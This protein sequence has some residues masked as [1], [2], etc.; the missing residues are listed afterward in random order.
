MR[1]TPLK[2][3]KLVDAYDTPAA[4]YRA[5]EEEADGVT[6]FLRSKKLEGGQY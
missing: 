5:N 2:K 1:R 6:I 3:K 4:E